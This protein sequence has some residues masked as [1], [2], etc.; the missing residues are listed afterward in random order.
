MNSNCWYCLED[1]TECAKGQNVEWCDTNCPIYKNVKSNFQ[2]SNLPE[3]YWW[4]FTLKKT[5]V[6]ATEIDKILSI[7]TNLS[8][9]VEEGRNVLLQSSKCGNGKTSWGIRLLQ[10]QIE[11]NYKGS[12]GSWPP[13]FFVYTPGLLLEARKSISSKNSNFETLQ[14]CIENSALVMFD[15]IGCIPLK[16]YDLLIL[17][18]LIENRLLKGLS[19]IYTTNLQGEALKEVLGERLF[20]RISRLS[21]V[22]TLKAESLRGSDDK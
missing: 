4:P 7:K 11:L 10:K 3:K 12:F 18:T 5:K 16:D 9:F 21:E 1:T 6:D 8:Q 2:K 22:I 17:S 14:L 15:D 13:A 19:S 20:D